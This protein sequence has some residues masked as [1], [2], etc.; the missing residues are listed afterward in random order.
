MRR[1]N[2]ASRRGNAA[3]ELGPSNARAEL[4]KRDVLPGPSNARAGLRRRNVLVRPDLIH[5]GDCALL[6]GNGG[7]GRGVEADHHP[8]GRAQGFH[9]RRVGR[10]R[11]RGGRPL[12]GGV[13][14]LSLRAAADQRAR[15]R[16]EQGQETSRSSQTVLRLAADSNGKS[17][18]IVARHARG[19]RRL[20]GRKIGPS[21][22][23]RGI[24]LFRPGRHWYEL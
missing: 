17:T 19:C 8:G 6:R 24:E 7:R 12:L 3:S 22:N 13:M 20:A 18:N 11:R 14:A 9:R 15:T 23:S 5:R 21:R 1:G 16:E 10:G 2:A 4:R